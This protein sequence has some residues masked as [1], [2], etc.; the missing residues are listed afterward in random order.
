ML[1]KAAFRKAGL[2]PFDPLVV[3]LKMKEY[4]GIQETREESVSEDENEE[5][6]FVTP[7][8]PPP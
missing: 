4:G 1:C 5:P 2:I 3:L 6:A 7:P 8:P